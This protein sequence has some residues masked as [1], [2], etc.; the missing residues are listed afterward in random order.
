M[1][2]YPDLQLY[3]GGAWRKAAPGQP[4]LN[5]ADESV[6][7]SVPVASRADLDDALA[8]AAEGL[9]VWSR[10][11]PARRAEV[12]RKAAALM[13]ERIE[14]IAFAIT[15]EHGKPIAQAR[16]EVIRGCEFL[17]WDAGEGQRTYGH[18]IPSEPGIKYIVV[19]RPIGVVA[20]FSPWN[21]PMS[22]PARKVG[23]GTRR[24]LLDHPEG[25][26]G[27]AGRRVAHRASL[28]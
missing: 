9:K 14:E 6:I 23:G 1:P 26:G 25:R 8:A 15:L 27:D 3:I 2:Q 19:H 5:P 13:R 17:E 12:I 18:V 16:L 20:A 10:T 4:V 24:R 21:F 11:S 28:S 7:G 22:Q